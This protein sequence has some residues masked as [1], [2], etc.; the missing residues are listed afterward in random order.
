MSRVAVDPVSTKKMY[1]MAAPS[2]VVFFLDPA[3]MA[4]SAHP[5]GPARDWLE[6]EEAA[7]DLVALGG[8]ALCQVRSIRA[9]P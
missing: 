8:G 7:A 5:R 1:S 4:C 2:V 3:G 6:E 9:R